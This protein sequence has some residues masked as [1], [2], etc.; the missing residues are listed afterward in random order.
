MSVK[1]LV[2]VTL[3]HMTSD[4]PFDYFVDIPTHLGPRKVFLEHLKGLVN[5]KVIT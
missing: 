4:T 2:E 1:A 3:G 5:A